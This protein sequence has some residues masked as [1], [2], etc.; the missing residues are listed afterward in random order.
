MVLLKHV[1]A[2]GFVFFTNYESRKARD[3]EANPRA[4]L[5]FH[6]P[7]LGSQVRIEGGV[8]RVPAS[9][10]DAYF[11]ARPRDSQLA[12]WASRQ[13]A[14]LASRGDLLARHEEMGRRFADRAVPR[15]PFWGGYRVRPELIEL[16]QAEDHRLHHRICFR[17]GPEGWQREILQP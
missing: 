7:S 1:D 6:W 9:Q 2:D 13:S 4:A 15:P 8:E 16:W 17:R 12:A 11:A 14:T 10:S 3:L 5:C